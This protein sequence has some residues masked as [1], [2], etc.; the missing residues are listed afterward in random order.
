MRLK[1][2]EC[3]HIKLFSLYHHHV[4]K[5]LLRMKIPEL[6]RKKTEKTS[7]S[8]IF[9]TNKNWNAKLFNL[10]A[11]HNTIKKLFF[12]RIQSRFFFVFVVVTNLDY[13]DPLK[14][15]CCALFN[16]SAR[17]ALPVPKQNLETRNENKN[18]FLWPE[19]PPLQI[20]TGLHF[21]CL[22]F[23]PVSLK[24]LRNKFRFL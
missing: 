13:E 22:T 9:G 5:I 7:P 23:P 6:R 18:I 11:M 16:Y 17:V 15:C 24:W 20:I 1:Y 4:R 2:F 8:D 3:K 19:S 12:P 10:L 14:W 21:C